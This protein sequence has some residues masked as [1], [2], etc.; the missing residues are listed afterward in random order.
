MHAA[1]VALLRAGHRPG[2]ALRVPRAGAV[3]TRAGPSLQLGQAADRPVRQ[4]HR[5][6]DPLG[7]C[8]RAPLRPERRRG[9][10][11]H[12]GHQRLRA[13]D[14]AQPRGRPRL[15][16][17]GRPATRRALVA[18]R[19]LRDP[20][21]GVHE[22]AL[23]RARR[24]AGHLRRA[25][26]R[27]CD[28][29]PARPGGHRGGAAPRP[30]HR[31]RELP[32]RQGPV[33]L[34]GVQLDR[35]PRTAR[36][37]R[38]DRHDG[39]ADPRV[40]GDGQGA[41][42]RRHRGDPRRRLQPHGRGQPPGPDALVQGRRQLHVLPAQ[43][44][45]PPVL[46]GLHGHRELAERH[47]P[48]RAAAHHGLAA[49]LGDRVPRRR[50]PLRPRVGTGPRALRR[51]PAVRVLRRH[52]PGSRAVAG[53]AHRRAL[54]RRPRRLPGRQL[55]DPLD[56]V[57]RHLPGRGPRL[58]A[59]ARL[60]RGLRRAAGRLERPVRRRTA[61]RPRPSTSSPRTTASRWPISSRTTTSTTRR[62]SRTTATAPTTTGR[63]TAGPR[64][65]RTTPRSASCGPA[66]SATCSP[67]SCCPRACP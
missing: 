38:R 46:H 57:E 3:R 37:L 60:G 44:R 62:T 4:G 6:S 25:R 32:P 9:R 27:G 23:V 1:H 45:G 11:P 35:L 16:L 58:L 64:G 40:Q 26:L 47:P 18:H 59:R 36:R 34:L 51:R 50:V 49:L 56:R 10:R 65:R 61:P 43:P 42:P 15:R 22:A 48:E 21:Q 17:G 2:A 67:R 30:P 20:C 39:R 12:P 53:E 7:R 8:E 54:G 41:A 13:G 29:P 28:R 55:P 14:P 63:G 31:R 33:Q 52:P 19:D 24:P 66:S 5:R